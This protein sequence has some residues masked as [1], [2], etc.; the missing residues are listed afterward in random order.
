MATKLPVAGR[1]RALTALALAAVLPRVA[2]AGKPLSVLSFNVLAPLWAATRWYPD[3]LDPALLD[4]AFRR[5][6]V[7]AFYARRRPRPRHRLPASGG[8]RR[9]AVLPTSAGWRVCR[10]ICQPRS[11]LLVE[12]ARA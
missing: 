5:E 3:R 10:R 7:T 12:L 4:R 1:R 6:R 8:S 9:N 2:Q 11:G